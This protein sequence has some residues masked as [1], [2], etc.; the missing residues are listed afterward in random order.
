VTPTEKLRALMAAIQDGTWKLEDGDTVISND[1]LAR[2][3]TGA[4]GIGYQRAAAILQPVHPALRPMAI[5][6]GRI[7]A[8]M[9]AGGTFSQSVAYGVREV[10]AGRCEHIEVNLKVIENDPHGT[11][12]AEAAQRGVGH[13]EYLRGLGAGG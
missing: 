8:N 1:E 6:E 9:G 7:A 3:E 13:G 10:L 12:A 5:S 11:I 4:L 2:W